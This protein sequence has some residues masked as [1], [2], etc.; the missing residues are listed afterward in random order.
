MEMNTYHKKVVFHL[1]A[2]KP[3][4]LMVSEAPRGRYCHQEVS[5]ATG[6]RLK[7]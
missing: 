4:A 6:A 1:S 3:R 5:E 7:A 2:L